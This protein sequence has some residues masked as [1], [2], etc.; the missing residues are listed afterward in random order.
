M[1]TFIKKMRIHEAWDKFEMVH[2]AAS[3]HIY[4]NHPTMNTV[5]KKRTILQPQVSKTN[6]L[7]KDCVDQ[8]ITNFPVIFEECSVGEIGS[9][10]SSGHHAT[11]LIPYDK[12]PYDH[13]IVKVCLTGMSGDY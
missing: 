11:S 6:I 8:I 7:R 3:V 2:R 10:K 9:I 5:H 12:H 4:P 1:F 13:F